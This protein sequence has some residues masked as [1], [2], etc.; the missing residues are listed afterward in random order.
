M[1]IKEIQPVTE[2]TS[3]RITIIP[4]DL[5]PDDIDP[6]AIEAL[7]DRLHA[8]A[9][10]FLRIYENIDQVL[11]RGVPELA[12][13][14]LAYESRSVL[15]RTPAAS[16]LYL[17]KIFDQALRDIGMTAVRSNSIFATG[18]RDFAKVFGHLYVIIPK[19][20]ANFTWSL[21][22]KDLIISSMSIARFLRAPDFD[23]INL[24]KFQDYYEYNSTDFVGSV[25]SGN[26]VMISGEYFAIHWR[27]WNRMADLNQIPTS[28]KYNG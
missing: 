20:T 22:K 28:L 19:N 2:M 16:D 6:A 10:K 21:R 27:L 13:F 1:T 9:G 4:G 18:D 5:H 24:E 15:D 12:Q 7:V 23:Q 17:S 25:R 8:E 3:N 14:A 11:W 26:E